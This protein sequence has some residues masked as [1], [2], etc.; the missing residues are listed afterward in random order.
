M[1]QFLIAVMILIAIL[2]VSTLTEAG[3]IAQV[4]EV[5][6]DDTIA[7]YNDLPESITIIYPTFMGDEGANADIVGITS[8]DV[9]LT[10]TGASDSLDIYIKQWKYVDG[11][12]TLYPNDSFYVA[13]A[14][15]WATAQ[16][17]SWTLADTAYGPCA[18][19]EIYFW[20]HDQVGD[21]LVVDARLTVQ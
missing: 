4:Q 1:K 17:Y 6:G 7:V 13:T 14:F 16:R 12:A 8:V 5:T 2:A 10:G 21:S 20:Y 9:L 3:G 15:D 11:V 19:L 18:G